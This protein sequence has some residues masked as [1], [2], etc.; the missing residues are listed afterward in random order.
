MQVA[1]RYF[2][3]KTSRTHQVVL[4]V[5]GDMAYLRGDAER[6]CPLGELKVSERTSYGA[7]KVTFP[8]GA[9]LEVLDKAAFDLLLEATGHRDSFVVRLQHSWR[10]TLA[11]TAA[12]VAVLT[13]SY[14]YLLPVAAGIVADALPES[15]EHKLGA[16]ALAFLDEHVLKP[17]ELPA[18]QRSALVE[19]FASLTAPLPDHP[20]YQVLFRKASIGPNAFA[21][22]S[23][24]IVVTDELA[25]LLADD[26]DAM[27]AVLAHELGHLHRHH[28][29]RR[30]IQ[31]SAIAATTTLLF[32]DVSAIVANF[33][34]VMLDL[35][36]SRDA[37][38]EADDYAMDMLER[39]GIGLQHMDLVFQRLGKLD[40][41]AAPYLST[42]PLTEERRQ[43]IRQREGSN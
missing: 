38:R 24:Q 37:E 3:G 33:P 18:G 14:F 43:R 36:Y 16:G 5:E 11:A 27:M 25:K 32:G 34:T 21:L 42:H 19:K 17:S 30:L 26:D 40:K 31:T 23:G 15:V 2:D 13:L 8:D 12:I 28:L 20:H 9:Y 29:T 39:N 35:K 7:R 1:A 10:A 41:G 4:S 22:P 6:D